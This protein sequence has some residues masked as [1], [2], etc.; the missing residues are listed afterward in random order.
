MNG[1]TCP[2]HGDHVAALDP[3][4]EGPQPDAEIR[5][6]AAGGDQ[7]AEQQQQREGEAGGGHADEVG[8]V[9]RA[10]AYREYHR[11]GG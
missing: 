9:A 10:L 1:E 5:G 2:P 11:R 4:P 7:H 6:E 3:L 8:R